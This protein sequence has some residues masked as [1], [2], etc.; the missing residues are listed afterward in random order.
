MSH[1]T[2]TRKSQRTGIRDVGREAG[3]SHTA[4]SMILNGKMAGTPETR[5]RVFQAAR[6]LNYRPDALFRQAVSKRLQG[7]EGKR[8]YT[9]I[10]ALLLRT[11]VYTRTQANDG[12]YSGVF[13][14]ACKAAAE[15]GWNILLCPHDADTGGL[16]EVLLDQKA[17]GVLIES[18]YDF[19][20]LSY[21]TQQFPCALLNR[22]SPALNAI[23]VTPNWDRAGFR[24]VQHAWELGHRHFVFFQH[25]LKDENTARAR[26]GQF[27][28]LEALGGS[29]TCPELSRPWPV[30]PER[31]EEVFNAFIDQWLAASPRPTAILATD[32]YCRGLIRAMTARGIRVPE[33]VSF[34]GRAGNFVATSEEP[35]LT[36]YIYP[37]YEIGYTAT[38]L[39]LETIRSGDPIQSTHV[40]LEGELVRRN[41]TREI[42]PDSLAP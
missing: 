22:C 33:D 11:N 21:L 15:A 16:P 4:V 10:L 5:E 38:R 27:L 29:L 17:D 24:M 25:T 42:A 23:S 26:H 19:N 31:N 35:Q 36:S 39:L 9:K 28:A 12:Y 14:G 37:V 7:E 18:G 32:G 41:S 20:L 2:R 6:K 13:A 3:V 30:S 1:P 8:T 34:F 40:M